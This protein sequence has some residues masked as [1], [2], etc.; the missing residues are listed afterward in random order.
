MRQ[1]QQLTP[2]PN[3][4]VQSPGHAGDPEGEARLLLLKNG[5]VRS[6]EKGSAGGTSSPS[7]SPSAA[8]AAA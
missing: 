8:A 6:S 1:N 5:R 2:C 4:I 3:Q 7:S